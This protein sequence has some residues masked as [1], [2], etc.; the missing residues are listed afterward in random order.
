MPE[1]GTHHMQHALQHPC[2]RAT[3]LIKIHCNTS[4]GHGALR[5]AV[6]AGAADSAG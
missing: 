6:S 5:A 2:T 4:L 1:V 3:V